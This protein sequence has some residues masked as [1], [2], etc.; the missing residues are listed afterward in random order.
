MLESDNFGRIKI[1]GE[2]TNRYLC[3][4]KKGELVPRVRCYSL[5]FFFP[6]IFFVLDFEKFRLYVSKMSYTP[7]LV[8]ILGSTS[9]S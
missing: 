9:N 7:N 5:S 8:D 2:K 3:I 6:L 4:N 1:R